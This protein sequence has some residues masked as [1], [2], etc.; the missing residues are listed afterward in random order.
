MGRHIRTFQVTQFALVTRLHY[1]VLLLWRESGGGTFLCINE[2]KQQ[3]EGWAEIETKPA[4]MTNVKHSRHLC[5]QVFLGIVGG[6][7]GIIGSS[8]KAPLRAMIAKAAFGLSGHLMDS[9]PEKP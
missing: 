6:T 7:G 5:T 3:R 8:H 2:F 1:G 9:A 4:S